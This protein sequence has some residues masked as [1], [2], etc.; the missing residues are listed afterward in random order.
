ML[1]LYIALFPQL[2]AGPI[3]RYETI[4][5]QIYDRKENCTLFCEGV[6]RFVIGM[7]KKVLLANNMAIMADIMFTQ[8][9]GGGGYSVTTATVWLGAIAYTFQIYFDFS[10]YSDMAIGLGKLFGF[11]F[12]ENFDYPYTASNVTEFWYKWH[13]SLSTWFRDYVYIP[14]GGNRCGKKRHIFNLFAV[15]ILTGIW[16]GAN[17]TFI[18]W[19]LLYFVILSIEK[20]CLKPYRY[21]R[22]IT[23]ISYQ[24]ATIIIIISAWVIFRSETISQAM[25]YLKNMFWIGSVPLQDASTIMFV[26]EFGI[27]FIASFIA[28]AP[29]EYMKS[30]VNTKIK[31]IVKS[32]WMIMIFFISII[33]IINST[34]NPFI[35]FNF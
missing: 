33:Y 7:A 35:Y 32:L 29:H 11:Q 18:V 2:I 22:S 16:H 21:K 23:K 9:I 8:N 12:E 19:G 30:M 25:I 28:A 24:I 14:L 4:E 27:F 5:S 34:Y 20:F 10:G 31:L 15:W 26:K 17:W 3:V 1:G 6:E 13:I